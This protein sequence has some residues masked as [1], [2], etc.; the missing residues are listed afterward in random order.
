MLVLGL[1]EPDAV[2]IIGLVCPSRLAYPDAMAT[3]V[4]ITSAVHTYPNIFENGD[5]FLRFSHSVHMYT[6]FSG[7]KNLRFS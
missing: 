6:V 7:P 1:C 4:A 2:K 3:R 5:F